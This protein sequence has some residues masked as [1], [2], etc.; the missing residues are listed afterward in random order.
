[1]GMAGQ[2]KMSWHREVEESQEPME[3]LED[4]QG[5]PCTLPWHVSKVKETVES[6]Y[7]CLEIE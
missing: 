1:M 3:T 7:L 2:E 5:Q 6:L 4:H